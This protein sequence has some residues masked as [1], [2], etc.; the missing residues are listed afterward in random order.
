MQADPNVGIELPL[1]VRSWSDARR[2]IWDHVGRELAQSYDVGAHGAGLGTMAAVLPISWE[3]R[4]GSQIRA[5][6]PVHYP[7]RRYGRSEC[8]EPGPCS[9]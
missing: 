8:E 7:M 6:T 3:T 5:V 9:A 4:P 1:G 2:C